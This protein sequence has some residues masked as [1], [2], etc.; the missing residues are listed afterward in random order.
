MECTP[1]TTHPRSAA[2]E[3][4]STVPKSKFFRHLPRTGNTSCMSRPG[5]AAL[6]RNLHRVGS[7]FRFSICSLG[8][9]SRRAAAPPG[10]GLQFLTAPPSAREQAAQPALYFHCPLFPSRS[11]GSSPSGVPRFC[12]LPRRAPEAKDCRPGRRKTD[13]EIVN[14]GIFIYICTLVSKTIIK[15]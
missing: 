6:G 14:S 3:R 7:P 15:L 12:F 13:G 9:Q 10:G 11:C 8:S 1:S 5:Q 2:F 4:K